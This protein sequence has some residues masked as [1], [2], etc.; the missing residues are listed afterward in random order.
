M[1]ES[2]SDQ[3]V[4]AVRRFNRFYTRKIGLLHEGYLASAFSLTEGR[5]LYELAHQDTVT[6]GALREIRARSGRRIARLE[7]RGLLER[8]CSSRRPPESSF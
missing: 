4:A 6:A 8:T 3:R 2:K 1:A 7:K 5:V